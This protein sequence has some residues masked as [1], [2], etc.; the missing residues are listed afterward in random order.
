VWRDV[1]PHCRNRLI[2]SVC[3]ALEQIASGDFCL[4]LLQLAVSWP[5]LVAR[6]KERGTS[7]ISD[8]ADGGRNCMSCPASRDRRSPAFAYRA[9]LLESRILLAAYPMDVI[10]APGSPGAGND[11]P[12]IDDSPTVPGGV[13]P[14]YQ[15]G[16]RWSSTASGGTGSTGQGI[17]LT[18]SI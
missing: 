4:R 9:E 5:F 6:T 8:P 17:T 18:Y 10:Y 7:C 14:N 15:I 16:S 2:A 13:T 3:D 1:K 12:V 11:T